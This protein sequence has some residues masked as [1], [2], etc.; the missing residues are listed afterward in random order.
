M[1]LNAWTPADIARRSGDAKRVARGWLARRR[2]T[3]VDTPTNAGC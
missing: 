1:A 2:E 3:I